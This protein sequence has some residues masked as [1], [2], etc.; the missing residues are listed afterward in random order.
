MIFLDT[1]FLIAIEVE[2]DQHHNEAMKILK[3][4]SSGIYG[5]AYISDYIFDEAVTLV[6]ARTNDIRRAIKF[7]DT[8]RNSSEFA[9][10]EKHIFERAW[11]I[12]KT[13]S[14]SELSFTDCT[15]V[16]VM[17]NLGI[18]YLVTFDGGFNR[19]KGVKVVRDE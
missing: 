10:I 8:L 2:T 4:I 12:F 14:I 1:G 3:E 7:G 11:E 5:Q 13:Q 19:F 17:E 6:A 16:A 9:L 18:K 15:N